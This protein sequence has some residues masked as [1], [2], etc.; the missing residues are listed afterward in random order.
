MGIIKFYGEFLR[1]DKFKNVIYD[2]VPQN[3]EGVSIDMNGTLHK[4]AQKNYAYAY[5]STENEKEEAKELYNESPDLLKQRYFTFLS[6]Y[7][8]EILE[9]TK[10]KTYMVMCVD[11]I[12]PPAKINQQRSRRY[13]SAQSSPLLFNPIIISPGT[14]FMIEIDRFIQNWIKVNRRFLPETVIYSSH[15]V[16]GEGEHKIFDIFREQK[17]KKGKGYHS[18]IGMDADLTMLSSL[19]NYDKILLIRENWRNVLNI[20]N[21]KDE[22]CV[23]M[24]K[25]T[26]LTKKEKRVVIQ[27]FVL[28]VFLLGNDFLPHNICLE[29]VAG[30]MDILFN[31]YTSKELRLTDDLGNIVWS[32]F[33]IF[34]DELAQLEPELLK[35]KGEKKWEFENDIL[36]SV[37][38]TDDT[39]LKDV[40]T[41]DTDLE[42]RDVN[43][44][45]VNVKDVEDVKDIE[46]TNIKLK[47]EEQKYAK[48]RSLWYKNI[49]LPKSKIAKNVLNE[50]NVVEDKNIDEMS[51]NYLF[52][53]QW[54]LKYYMD[55]NVTNKFIYNYLHAPLFDDIAFC[56]DSEMDNLPNLASV[57][58]MED[59][60]KDL[61]VIHQL[62]SIIPPRFTDLIPKKWRELD[63]LSYMCPSEFL[64]EYLGTDVSF[65]SIAILPPLDFLK[66][67]NEVNK[68]DTVIPKELRIQTVW[69]NTDDRKI[70]EKIVTSKYYKPNKRKPEEV[71]KEEVKK[72]EPVYVKKEEPVYVKKYETKKTVFSEKV[73]K[74]EQKQSFGNFFD[75]FK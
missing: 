53:I 36:V 19:S 20:D 49:F 31:I 10:P 65:A 70:I 64:I 59:D 62:V 40:N 48:F 33:Y 29:N 39:V 28:L 47:D 37:Y 43:A 14:K 42:D 38:K 69:I 50:L 13:L 35:K 2:R 16:P 4:I 44:E 56:I 18:I 32:K 30:T 9:V 12:A 45:D 23:H 8:F 1:S 55:N 3:I 24:T 25:N 54:N 41:K 73:S 67:V 52:G 72:E 26:F 34:I 5:N 7:L 60:F 63:T 17:V 68:I 71:K 21:F 6:E 46:T 22:I 66:V 15:L 11:G 74:P 57:S 58:P 75:S 61:N 27:D 51:K